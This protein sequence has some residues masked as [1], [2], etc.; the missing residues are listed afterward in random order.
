[1]GHLFVLVAFPNFS[2]AV[3][4][5]PFRKCSRSGL[6]FFQYPLEGM[7]RTVAGGAFQ[8]NFK[9]CLVIHGHNEV[10][11]ICTCRTRAYVVSSQ[12][13]SKKTRILRGLECVVL[14]NGLCMNSFSE[15]QSLMPLFCMWTLSS[16][17]ETCT[18]IPVTTEVATASTSA[19]IVFRMAVCTHF[20]LTKYQFSC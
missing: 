19:R 6:Q 7:E 10:D 11:C 20:N 2:A 14:A 13:L 8:T 12:E 1:V 18:G 17:S 9:A 5:L 4:G 15:P 3:C 16:F